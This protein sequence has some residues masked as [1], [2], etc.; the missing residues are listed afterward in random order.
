MIDKFAPSE[1]KALIKIHSFNIN[2]WAAM[3]EGPLTDVMKDAL[4]QTTARMYELIEELPVPKGATN[5]TD[6]KGFE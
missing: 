3:M 4:L 5:K 2:Q 1:A 6:M